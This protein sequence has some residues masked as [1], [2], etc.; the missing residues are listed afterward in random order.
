MVKAFQLGNGLDRHLLA[1][2]ANMSDKGLPIGKI[3]TNQA[4][5]HP[6]RLTMDKSPVCIR[7]P[8]TC[9][10]PQPKDLGPTD[11][12]NSPTCFRVDLK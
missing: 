3:Q 1:R 6:Q 12:Q 7:T 5:L 9:A 4:V 8:D 2:L 11:F 10:S